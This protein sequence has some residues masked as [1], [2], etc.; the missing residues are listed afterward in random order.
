[1]PSSAAE[2]SAKP[3]GGTNKADMLKYLY[4]QCCKPGSKPNGIC[5]FKVTSQCDNPSDFNGGE[6]FD[7][8][9]TCAQMSAF[10]LPSSVGECSAKIDGFTTKADT[11]KYMYSK[12]CKPGSKPNGI[13]GFKHST[14]T[15]C[16]S[17]AANEFL[18]E[19]M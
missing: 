19:A 11:L 16:Q 15:P 6:K 17:K 2:C 4:G 5:G 8:E 9:H 3:D 18:P 14:A 1:M 13:C 10:M 12:C 7:E